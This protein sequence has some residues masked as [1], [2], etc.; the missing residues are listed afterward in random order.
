MKYKILLLIFIISLISSIFILSTNHG[1]S[2]FCQPD[3]GCN[4]V[5]NSKYSYLFGISNSIYGTFIFLILS[6]ITFS[7]IQKPIKNK[8]LLINSAVILGFIVAIYFIFIQIFIIKA[9]CKYCL[10]IDFSLI[11][12]F[13]LVILKKNN[14]Q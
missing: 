3:G 5:Q 12:A 10:V 14:L 13:F 7:Q 1:N 2:G 11:I 4:A 6:M 9:F 8:Q